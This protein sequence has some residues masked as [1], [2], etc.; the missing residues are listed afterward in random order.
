MH[1]RDTQRNEKLAKRQLRKAERGRH[2]EGGEVIPEFQ[3]IGE[4]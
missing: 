3:I 1:V 4:V 2:E